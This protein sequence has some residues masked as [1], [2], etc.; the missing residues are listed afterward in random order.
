MIFFP[1]CF[2]GQ[3]SFIGLGFQERTTAFDFNVCLQDH[4]KHVDMDKNA[5]KRRREYES[6]PQKDYSL[7][8]GQSIHISIPGGPAGAAKPKP[9]ASPSPAGGFS[10][11]L[12][13]PPSKGQQQQQQQQQPP[14]QQQQQVD[15]GDFND[16]ANS[17]GS[18]PSGWTSFN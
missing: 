14:Q 2:A 17:S 9:A 11:L 6:Q 13:P 18:T 3:H 4:I 7:G 5:E 12:P 8:S 15:W 1:I 10:A 16:S